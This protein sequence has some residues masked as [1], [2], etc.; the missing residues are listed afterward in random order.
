MSFVLESVLRSSLLL[1]IGLAGVALLR[2]KPAALRHWVLMATLVL[3]AAQPAMNRIVPSWKIVGAGWAGSQVQ[4]LPEVR[5]EV[6]FDLPAAASSGSPASGVGLDRDRVSNLGRWRDG[7]SRHPADRRGV[8][9]VA[10]LSR[11]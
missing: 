8:A 3:A 1:A 9:H 6:A 11:I 10:D 7:R 4:K 5:T 2:H